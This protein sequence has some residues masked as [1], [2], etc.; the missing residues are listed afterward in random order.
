[1]EETRVAQIYVRS[2]RTGSGYLLGADL[3]LTA[4]HVVRDVEH[5][6]VADIEVLLPLGETGGKWLPAEIVWPL[7][8]PDLSANP[9]SDVAL[10]RIV[11]HGRGPTAERLETRWGE[12]VGPGRV[13]CEA[14]GFAKAEQQGS[15]HDT[16]LA[17][18]HIEPLQGLRYGL[19]VLHITGIVPRQGGWAGMSGAAVFCGP[20]LTGV[21]LED[22]G[23]SDR[24]E[25]LT[26]APAQALMQLPG[27]AAVLESAALG[28]AVERTTEEDAGSRA[29]RI[30][31][32]LTGS[33]LS[34]LPR[35]P[36][37][38]FVGRHTELAL[39]CTLVG[40]GQI[41]PVIGPE[42]T[43][44][45]AFIHKLLTADDFR[46]VLPEGRPPILLALDIPGT[47]I[48][49]PI[50]QRLAI[51]L[52]QGLADLEELGDDAA[53][54][55]AKRAHLVDRTLAA[56]AR[57]RALVLTVD[58]ALLGADTALLERD[59][60]L[61]LV[62]PVFKS[63]VTVTASAVPIEAAGQDQLRRMRP[64]HLGGLAPDE[65]RMLLANL[66]HEY[67]IDVDAAEVLDLLE[68]DDMVRRPMI[69]QI[70]VDRYAT[71][72]SEPDSAMAS[73]Q[74]MA[75]ELIDA[76]R[77]TVA[78][79]LGEAQCTLLTADGKPGPLA[80][81]VIWALSDAYPLPASAW[82]AVGV[83][84][85]LVARLTKSR[86]LL[87]YPDA[88]PGAP[89]STARY[90]LSKVSRNALR[91]LLLLA[92]GGGGGRPA[93]PR[94]LVLPG[95]DAK[96][97][98]PGDHDNRERLD[99][100]LA[101]AANTLRSVLVS[102]V[103]DGPEG[104]IDAALKFAGEQMAGWLRTNAA[105][106][107]PLTLQVVNHR[108]H[109]E[110]IGDLFSPVVADEESGGTPSTAEP[111]PEHTRARPEFA[112]Y[113]ALAELNLAM[114][115]PQNRLARQRFIDA[116]RAAADAV[117]G[118]DSELPGHLIRSV[119]SGFHFGSRRFQCQA[120]M[121]P[122][123][124][125]L[126]PVLTRQ[127][128]ALRPGRVGRLAWTASWILNAAELHLNAADEEG[129]RSQIDA[130][131]EL[132]GAL[133]TP[134]TVHGSLTRLSLLAR[135]SRARARA[136]GTEEVRR[137]ALDSALEINKTA[138]RV[139]EATPEKLPLWTTRFLDS[140]RSSAWE[141]G[142]DERREAAVHR[143]LGVLDEVH[144]ERASWSSDV[145]FAAARFARQVLNRQADPALRLV[146]ARWVLDLVADHEEGARRRA[147]AGDAA[148]VLELSRLHQF[149]ASA[150]DGC[151]RTGEAL[152][153][154]RW[155]EQYAEHAVRTVPSADSY[156]LW[157][158]ALHRREVREAPVRG[159]ATAVQLPAVKRATEAAREWLDR[160]HCPDTRHAVLD[161]WCIQEE[162]HRQGRTLAAAVMRHPGPK[163]LQLIHLR[164]IAALDAHRR[165]Y[166]RTV[167]EFL[168][169]TGVEVEY[170]R[171]ATLET[172]RAAARTRPVDYT[173]VLD[174]YRD[175]KAE[176]PH[177]NR[178]RFSE[179]SFGRYVWEVEKAA[180]AFEAIVRS[181]RDGLER[182]TAQIEL[183]EALLRR[184]RFERHTGS[185][186]Y[187]RTLADAT[188]H[189]AEPLSHV[190]KPARVVVL[191]AQ[192]ALE[193]E[194][195]VDWALIEATYRKYIDDSYVDA[196]TDVLNT[197]QVDPDGPTNRPG[198]P[199]PVPPSLSQQLQ[200]DFT[201]TELL[202]G[203]GE[204]YLRQSELGTPAGPDAMTSLRCAYACFN[205]CRIIQE[206]EHGAE[207]LVN[208]FLRARAIARAAARAKSKN[209][210]PWPLEGGGTWL[211]LGASLLQS[212]RDRSVGRFHEACW[213]RA[214]EVQRLLQR[215][216]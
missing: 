48:A 72:Q 212:C 181:A 79:A 39:A 204:L 154:V 144:G 141:I 110:S 203:L 127:A 189:L 187:S 145:R 80:P 22:R 173:S 38:G 196:I 168:L 90:G 153:A 104:D 152:A 120:E 148:A 135:L 130:A 50:L 67:G 8:P 49:H 82:D 81:M 40:P 63:C 133:P 18:G 163:A 192:I 100:L 160:Q 34:P 17:R 116:C 209:P 74:D 10:L 55:G 47:G 16:M 5:P 201:S 88:I 68:D 28:T 83:D 165:R 113:A 115:A 170:Q 32:D 149:H 64:V 118:L 202:Q 45:S 9:A 179:G 1:M 30:T 109:A 159:H 210:F 85:H 112:L 122:L 23:I 62:S 12:R 150:L 19:H 26:A 99:H 20:L 4:Y 86:I 184:A 140:A 125:A 73:A 13:P 92:T 146:A 77:V 151:E 66:L 91:N 98:G 101:D 124:S 29:V 172:T 11:A 60:D 183:A 214:A 59:L 191:Q 158:R 199:E 213:D 211:G 42:H 178:I 76:C 114:R 155:A 175:A 44:K 37:H 139:C 185:S 108:L 207:Y 7:T 89:A 216:R 132:L 27:F 128:V 188:G 182:R 106:T 200:L 102:V 206:A 137:A 123:R 193:S 107:L 75:C 198:E 164:R 111:V 194:S 58:C 57:N 177:D 215:L 46:R 117:R 52:D 43:G 147:D 157:L 103:S 180:E 51:T 171:L 143:S 6:I 21:V 3:I 31:P 14:L 134:D 119:D 197:S 205:A 61:T 131:E 190:F 65:A 156:H 54:V 69:L 15:Q 87:K 78:S 96:T 138:L 186:A 71:S 35:N 36:P 169:R 70:G 161:L 56:L 24:P 126:I 121:M 84:R 95:L 53:S 129:A 136:A 167:E 97:G 142:S 2:D 41:L 162:W 25:V 94:E 93:A 195:P 208:Q 105:D 33:G 176:W 166:P 174:G